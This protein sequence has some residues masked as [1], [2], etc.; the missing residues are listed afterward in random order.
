[1]KRTIILGLLLLAFTGLSA[2]TKEKEEVQKVL[3][4]YK[5]AVENLD[6]SGTLNNLFMPDAMVYENG[7]L[8]GTAAEFLK[9]HM[10]P[11]LLEFNSF[12]YNDYKSDII[13]AGN[14]AFTTETYG[15]TIVLKKDNKPITPNSLG[16]ATSILQKTK[17]GWKI[18]TYHFSYRKLRATDH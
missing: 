14:Y 6:A 1:M 7:K 15:Y 2:Q 16:V 12:T 3:T 4:A 5:T 10:H 18:M 11:E 17:F 9:I 8:E 13:I